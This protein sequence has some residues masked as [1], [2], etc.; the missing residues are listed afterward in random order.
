MKRLKIFIP[1]VIVL[2]A[3]GV[4][5]VAGTASATV[6][7][8]VASVSSCGLSNQYGI[9]TEINGHLR[10]GEWS[11]ME[12]TGTG[13]EWDVHCT[14]STWKMKT[15]SAGG[16]AVTVTA[17][18]EAFSFGACGSGPTP[19]VLKK[20]AIVFHWSL[21]NNASITEEGIE[22]TADWFGMSCVYGASK[23]QAIAQLTGGK[24]ATID[25]SMT[26]GLIKGISGVCPATAAWKASYEITAPNPLYATT[27]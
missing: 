5:A 7:C 18:T 2:A 14:E 16:G 13:P 10:S 15:T 17:A 19:V 24:P 11:L 23:P 4:V 26:L 3:T 12:A 25:L 22:I 6:L 20:P 1:T 8:K 27:S 9:G 21:G